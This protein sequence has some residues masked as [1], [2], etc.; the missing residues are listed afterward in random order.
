MPFGKKIF[1][2]WRHSDNVE[3]D[4]AGKDEANAI[5][6]TALSPSPSTTAT[7]DVIRKLFELDLPGHRMDQP[8]IRVYMQRTEVNNTQN[9]SVMNS[10]ENGNSGAFDNRNHVELNIHHAALQDIASLRKEL[11]TV[12]DQLAAHQ[13]AK[14]RL[15]TE[16]MALKENMQ[17][18]S[19]QE[20]NDGRRDAI[21]DKE[22]ASM[23]E[24]ESLIARLQVEKKDMTQRIDTLSTRTK[25]LEE[26][27]TSMK[28]QVAALKAELDAE[29]VEHN[30]GRPL[31]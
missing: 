3:K 10:D 13:L 12:R 8:P 20:S 25:D 19:D 23:H 17:T 4:N 22:M 31:R 28:S 16:N 29:R 14:L 15:Q 21:K 2:S 7:N 27:Q 30:T 5:P 18:S 6:R 26:K 9:L 24:Q 1:K 11:Q